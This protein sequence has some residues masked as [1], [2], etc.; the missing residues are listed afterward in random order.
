MTICR[1]FYTI[2]ITIL[3]LFTSFLFPQVLFRELPNYN[4]ELTNHS[5]FR[6]S[7]TRNVI[8]LN[9]EWSVYL[10][11]DGEQNRFN[12]SVPSIFTGET[13]VVF[14]KKINLNEDQILNKSITL[15]ILGLNYTA[16]ISVNN[17][18]IHRHAG[19]MVPF[20]VF[21]PKDIL[22]SDKPNIL[23]IELHHKLDSRN[24]IPLKQRFLFPQDFGGIIRDVFLLLQPNIAL[25]KTDVS[26]TYN[27]SDRRTYVKLSCT[28]INN[29][30]IRPDS[31]NQ[32]RLHAE[33]YNP[34]DKT[35]ICS[36]E[37]YFDLKTNQEK[38]NEM[39]LQAQIK[40]LWSP[41]NPFLYKLRISVYSEDK[42]IDTEEREMMFFD[43]VNSGE[44]Q[45]LNGK[46]FRFKGVTYVPTFGEPG[47]LAS[48]GQMEKDI[49]LIKETGFNS[50]RFTKTTPHPYLLDLCAR[51]GLFAFIEL[52]LNSI[53]ENLAS[54][55]NFVSRCTNYLNSFLSYYTSF[56][57]VT[58]IGLGGG[59][60][61]KSDSHR[62]LLVRLIGEADMYQNIITYASFGGTDLTPVENLDMS[63]IELINGGLNK[64]HNDLNKLRENFPPSSLFISEATYIVNKGN[65]DGY[66]NAQSYE[67]QAKYFSDL[68]D[69]STS[70]ELSG[71]FL[72]TMFDYRGDYASLTS[73]YN[74]N[75]L[76][77][78]GIASED[79]DIN[80]L[81]QKVV[82]SKLLDLEKVTIPIGSTKDDSPMVFVVIGLFLA[83]LVG[84]L[85]NSGRKF[86]EDASRALLRPYNFFADVRDQR[87]ISGYHTSILGLIITVVAALIV[88]NVLFYLRN[89]L[90][91][92]RYLLAFASPAL[93][94]IITY[95]SWN[96]LAAIL[97]LS[98]FFILLILMLVLI[99]KAA[100]FFIRTRVYLSSSYF[101]VI[102][103]FLPL[104]LLIPVGIVL[105][106]LLNLETGNLYI[107]IFLFLFGLLVLHRLLKGI[108][109]IYDVSPGSVYFYGLLMLI[110]ILGA[111]IL[112]Y[113]INNSVID[114]LRYVNEL[115][116][117][118]G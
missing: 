34:D 30:Q 14:E 59:Y 86:R 70:S 64:L 60:L 77:N 31:M 37:I 36:D 62:S 72:N 104:L 58:A 13:D 94:E 40:N 107:Y 42:L 22:N 1:S 18:I 32:F 29:S 93:M 52:P 110:I 20:S 82:K 111:V 117:T 67:A 41:E 65:T 57:S 5:V 95:L 96:P 49:K 103:S 89:D 92:E 8:S 108:Y 113:E 10:A 106:R 43:L 39:N 55:Q 66:V 50:V 87:I 88:A 19:G 16:D 24:T 74:D 33:I 68:I 53:P 80:R 85:V 45:S 7:E 17:I 100:S 76:Y 26:Y 15:N 73:G 63:G 54:D 69:L 51:Y 56:P 112:Y 9:G 61:P 102:W 3:S 101:T 35:I 27:S 2:L 78:I 44:K 46:A 79:R 4:P 90:I 97:W 81:T 12:V 98:V 71:F 114:H 21:L 99:V 25:G 115:Y 109:V 75:N 83:L 48:F 28:T 23:K 11:D 118:S 91:F 84:I 38:N 105:Y 116:N 6:Y 47:Y